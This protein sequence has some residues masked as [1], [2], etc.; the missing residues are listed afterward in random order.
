MDR[1][2]KSLENEKNDL[3]L[4]K[5]K[6]A[7]IFGFPNRFQLLPHDLDFYKDT[8]VSRDFL[9]NAEEM[10]NAI[11]AGS[12][13][14][15]IDPK[16]KSSFENAMEMASELL[17]EQNDTTLEKEKE[18]W[19]IMKDNERQRFYSF[20]SQTPKYVT[21]SRREEMTKRRKTCH[22]TSLRKI[23]DVENSIKVSHIESDKDNTKKESIN[24]LGGKVLTQKGSL[25]SAEEK[26]L[27]NEVSLYSPPVGKVCPVGWKFKAYNRLR[28]IKVVEGKG[29]K[30]G[31]NGEVIWWPG[32]VYEDHSEMMSDI[33]DGEYYSQQISQKYFF[34]SLQK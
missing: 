27:H 23:M 22:K 24:L 32:M 29:D 31:V 11:I 15:D 3:K 1:I 28:W 14:G 8:L 9:N 6:V 21:P 16:L 19:T 5:P 7:Y 30:Q 12:A 20:R 26:V 2:H 4:C 18:T 17:A 10:E 25:Y 13:S 34:L 33:H